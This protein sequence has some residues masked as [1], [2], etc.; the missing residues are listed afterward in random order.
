M[1]KII[2]IF[3]AAAVMA[4]IAATAQ[5]QTIAWGLAQPMVGDSEVATNGTYFDA[6]NLNSS[7]ASY[8][9]NGE[10]FN[11][12]LGG[13]VG[14]GTISITGFGYGNY[15][16]GTGVF[17]GGSTA[18]QNTMAGIDFVWGGGTGT[19]TLSSLTSGHTYQVQAW[20]YIG[21]ADGPT[22]LTGSTPVT[23]TS[24]GQFSIGAFTATGLTET[25]GYTDIANGNHAVI[26][27]VSVRDT[28]VVPEPS[29]W[30]MMLGGLGMLLAGQ[31]IRRRK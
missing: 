10:Q 5:A 16:G 21:G 6:V 31:R 15:T 18:Y 1:K 14:D 26:N 23:L 8:T 19:V 11:A 7:L 9:V 12:T 4:S 22:T 20:S 28:T 2:G 29:T 30:A 3:A 17:T 27:A 24:A 13:G 25:F